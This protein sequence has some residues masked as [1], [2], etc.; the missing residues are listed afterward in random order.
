LSGSLLL[1]GIILQ[2]TATSENNY[3]FYKTSRQWIW[4]ATEETVMMYS[5]GH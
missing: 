2:H 3:R 5:Q 1:Q 4:I